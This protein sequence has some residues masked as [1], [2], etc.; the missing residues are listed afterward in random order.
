MNWIKNKWVWSAVVAVV[1][2]LAWQTGVVT[3]D[4]AVE[5]A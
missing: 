3:P 1:I 4:V 5:A 2:L